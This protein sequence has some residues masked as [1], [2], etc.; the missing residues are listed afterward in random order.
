MMSTNHTAKLLIVVPD[1]KPHDWVAL[2]Q[3]P[4]H[5][6]R[7]LCDPGVVRMGS[8]TCK[9][10]PSTP[11]FDNRQNKD[12]LQKHGFDC[13]EVARQQLI[14]LMSHQM[15]PT[16]RGIALRNRWNTVATQNVAHRFVA[17]VVAQFE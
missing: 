13:E 9:M 2:F 11:D 3:F 5:L 7:L 17:D 1:E 12:R 15:T 14:F 4:H 10:H 16:G 8:A 6:A